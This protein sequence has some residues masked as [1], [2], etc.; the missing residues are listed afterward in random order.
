M[1][2]Q[3]GRM[4]LKLAK[5]SPEILLVVGAAAIIGGVITACRST[6]KV[7]EVIDDHKDRLDE[8]KSIP[9]Q[10]N[11]VEDVEYP[12]EVQKKDLTKLY[13]HTG[14]E[15]IKLYAAP[16]GLIAGGI[17]C[18]VV[19]SKQYKKR[20]LGAVAA[21]NGVAEAFKRYRKRVV[22]TEGAEKDHE[23]MYGKGKKKTVEAKTINDNGDE[24]YDRRQAI[25]MENGGEVP[26]SEYCR[27]FARGISKEWDLNEYY[28]R[29]FINGREKWFTNILRERGHVFLNEV[30]DG[31]GFPQTE[32][33]AV[34]GWIYNPVDGLDAADE[35][36][37][38]VH[39]V[40]LPEVDENGHEYHEPAYY[41]DFPNLSGIIFDK[42]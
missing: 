19:S 22:D 34:I 38:D 35:I 25:I 14:V 41:I 8:L 5:K 36:I 10:V 6:L 7:E 42:L 2:F 21:Y 26:L 30:L 9:D 17:T 20:Y 18:M 12:E 28:N 40:W 23:Y 1:K 24:V 37:F 15:F 31:L 16:I 3:L 29:T 4:K 39:E 32:A 13:L 33:G 27:F 11:P